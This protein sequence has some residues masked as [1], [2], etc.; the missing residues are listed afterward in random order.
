M[1]KHLACGST[2]APISWFK[3]CNSSND[4]KA[5]CRIDWFALFLGV[6]FHDTISG[7]VGQTITLTCPLKSQNASSNNPISPKRW[8]KRIAFGKS[9]LIA[10]SEY[11]HRSSGL[12][13]DRLDNNGSLVI[14]SVTKNDSGVY[15]CQFTSHPNYTVKLNVLGKYTT[16]TAESWTYSDRDSMAKITCMHHST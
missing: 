4:H 3:H 7:T 1:I 16:N 13:S 11:I 5:T 10:S 9:E 12:N 2:Y 6:R 14:K 15:K 8:F